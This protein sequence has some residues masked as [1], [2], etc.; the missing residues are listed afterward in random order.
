MDFAESYG[1]VIQDAVQGYHWNNNQATIHPFV[2]YYKDNE[3]L[4]HRTF[5]IVSDCNIH[6]HLY[7]SKMINFVKT[8]ISNS[9]TKVIYVSDG[10][11]AHYKN[12]S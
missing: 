2:V 9:I 3:I 11:G 8:N 12:T 6:V 4:I 7:I 5:V 10:G 1:F